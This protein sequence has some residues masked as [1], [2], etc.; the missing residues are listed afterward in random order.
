MS[1]VKN[2]FP[3]NLILF[4]DLCEV[5]EQLYKKKRQRQEQNKILATFLNNVRLKTANTKDEKVKVTLLY[6]ETFTLTLMSNTQK[7]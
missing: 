7:K 5:L 3:A 4:G 2:V 6:D 1:A